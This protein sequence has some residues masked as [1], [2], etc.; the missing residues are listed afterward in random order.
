MR[1]VRIGSVPTNKHPGAGKSV[2]ELA[3][4]YKFRTHLFSYDD[5][6]DKNLYSKNT[7]VNKFKFRNPRMP[8]NRR[9]VLF[10]LL[11]AWRLI[12]IFNYGCRVI[13]ALP[14]AKIDIIH[15]HS[16]IHFYAAVYGRLLGRSKIVLTVHGTDFTRL[17][18][19]KVY[20]YLVSSVDA[21]FV[22]TREQ[23]NTIKKLFPNTYVSYVG[24]GVDKVFLSKLE[25]NAFDR[26][27]P[28]K[29]NVISVGSLRWQKN[30]MLLLNAIQ[31]S[32]KLTKFVDLKLIGEGPDRDKLI[33][34]CEKYSLLNSVKFLGSIDVSRV[35]DQLDQADVFVLCSETEGLPK[36][37]LEAM[38]R[39][40]FCVT[41]DVGECRN[42]LAGT[43]IVIPSNSMEALKQCLEY[44]AE[45]IELQKNRRK[46]TRKIA[47][48][49]SWAAYCERH[50]LL[51]QK[52]L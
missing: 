23:E 35:K 40:C 52:L 21:I 31:E 3:N 9:G 50:F 30:Q 17:K 8:K 6:G 49:Y 5:G 7:I 37:L 24:N 15:I 47:E 34:F 32:V 39:G 25:E 2:L 36:A 13:F 14:K 46:K 19:S 33:H 38:A 48:T 16:P 18:H 22:V 12:A 1:V 42:V 10:V 45:N 11:Q 41:T 4:Y 43:G 29:L 28:S 27:N 20:R 44:L 51:Y 26:K